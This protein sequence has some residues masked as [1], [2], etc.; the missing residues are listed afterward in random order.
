VRRSGRRSV[1]ELLDGGSDPAPGIS[2][3]VIAT[4]YELVGAC[5]ALLERFI[6]ANLP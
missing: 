6:D 3:V 4:S 1:G 5:G 2:T